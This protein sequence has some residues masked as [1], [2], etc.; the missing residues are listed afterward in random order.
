[1][2]KK[3]KSNYIKPNS[4]LS[5]EQQMEIHE[6]FE[7][8]DSN[9]KNEIIA[10]EVLVAFRALNFDIG[11]DS[12]LEMLQ[13]SGKNL[14]S[15]VNYDEFFNLISLKM[16]ERDPDEETRKSFQLLSQDGQKITFESLKK[17]VKELNDNIL[18]DEDLKEIIVE[19]D[20]DEDGAI[21]EDD[22]IKIMKKTTYK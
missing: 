1:M 5:E 11:K 13:E 17:I 9:G 21:G 3:T 15:M 20:Y 6:T 7:L 19:A 4:P 8:L 16:I 14:Y 2:N 18:T 10:K 12:L 22:F